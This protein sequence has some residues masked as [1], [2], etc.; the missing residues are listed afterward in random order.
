[1][2]VNEPH[3][4][5]VALTPSAAGEARV[6]LAVDP[7]SAKCGVAV[8]RSDGVVLFRAIMTVDSLVEEARALVARFRPLAL[9]VGGG[10]GSGTLLRALEAARLPVP[11]RRVDEAHTSE[12]ARAR[13]VAEN[14]ARGWQRLLPR[15]L[16]TPW[17]PY[18]D[19]VAIILA[20]RYW[21]AEAGGL[22]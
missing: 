21:N 5:E 3:F 19:Y 13:F 22:P 12:A 16:R 9:L 11:V 6:I 7:G 20:E 18:D 4:S 2:P 14:P 17:C 15:S 1:M 10:T 8:V